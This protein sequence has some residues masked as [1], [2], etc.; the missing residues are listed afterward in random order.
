[1]KLWKDQNQKE[2]IFNNI[3]VVYFL[4]CLWRDSKSDLEKE[5]CE[6]YID[7]FCNTVNDKLKM[8][9]DRM[10][11]YNNVYITT[12]L[13]GYFEKYLKLIHTCSIVNFSDAVIDRYLN[14]YIVGRLASSFSIGHYLN[15]IALE[16]G[17]SKIKNIAEQNMK[18]AIRG[19]NPRLMTIT[20]KT[21]LLFLL[22][23]YEERYFEQINLLEN[24]VFN[25]NTNVD[26]ENC[27]LKEIYS[28]G[29]KSKYNPEIIRYLLYWVFKKYRDSK[30]NYERFNKI[31]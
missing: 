18:Y 20:E 13:M 30:M 10:N 31:F 27:L 6:E 2:I 26:I 29:S 15:G 11:S 25:F 9:F 28:V 23:S 22:S 24:G 12:S 1:M 14:L 17:H 8:Q 5:R 4:D 16:M 21:N 19:I 7:L 3:S